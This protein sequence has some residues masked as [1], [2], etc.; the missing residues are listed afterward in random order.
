MGRPKKVDKPIYKNISFPESIC[1]QVDL[2]LY[3]ELEG[4]VP[5]GAWSKYLTRLVR[6][7]LNRRGADGRA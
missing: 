2:K 7:D 4:R 6:E 3:S 1:A 5:H